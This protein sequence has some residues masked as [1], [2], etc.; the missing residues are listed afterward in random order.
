MASTTLTLGLEGEVTLELFVRAMSNFSGLVSALHNQID[1]DTKIE[2]VIESL[3][4]G[5]ATTRLRGESAQPEVVER[6][7]RA[8]GVVGKSLADHTPIPY[9]ADVVRNA[10]GLTSLLDGKI[11]ALRFET[12]EDEFTV[13]SPE[14]S[15]ITHSSADFGAV[16][17]RIQTISERGGLRFT[18]Y[19]TLEDKAV[20]C[21]LEPGQ[22]NLLRDLWGRR[23]RV[24]GLVNRDAVSGRPTAI[25]LISSIRPIGEV[26]ADSYLLVR[27]IFNP[28]EG[29]ERPEA[30]IR[31]LRDAQ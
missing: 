15:V 28:G 25:R 1:R 10:V 19:D 2:W 6:V 13:V 26:P 11:E 22:G 24:E 20:T 21:Y 27:G 12:P 8:Y 9:A 29:A 30:A 16:E 3:E 4:S 14:L 18:L 17:G 23:A 5:S 31:R 7:V